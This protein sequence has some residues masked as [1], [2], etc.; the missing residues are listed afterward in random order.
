MTGISGGI[1]LAPEII[2]A[3]E[4]LLWPDWFAGHLGH[5]QLFSALFEASGHNIP[6]KFR[7]N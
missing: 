4:Q 1:I 6:G 7:R 2:E 3:P 5:F